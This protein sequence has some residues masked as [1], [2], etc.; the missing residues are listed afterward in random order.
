MKKILFII[1]GLALM[2]IIYMGINVT[3]A[4]GAFINPTPTDNQ[5][6]QAVDV[7]PGTE[8]VTIDQNTGMVFVSAA[9]RRVP[10][11][12]TPD[13]GGIYAFP[14]D[15]PSSVR[16]VSIDG[17]AD[18]QPH[19]I[20]LWR[21]DRGDGTIIT[22]LFVIN[23]ATTGENHIE[24][25]DVAA[26]GSLSYF[27]SIQFQDL[28][29][30]NDILAVGPSSFYATIDRKYKNGLMASLEAYL[31]LPLASTVYFDGF[32]GFTAVEGLKYANGINMSADGN[33]VYIAEVL[34][35]EIGVYARTPAS[36]ALKYIKSIPV[37]TGPDNIEVGGDGSLYVAGHPYVFEFLKHAEDAA[38][39]SP[40]QVLKINP[41]TDQ[42]DTIFMDDQ[43][44][45]NAASV[46]AP[47]GDKLIIGAVFD[48]HVLVCAK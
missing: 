32:E 6:C 1:G 26:D 15:D 24:L 33:I 28:T 29:S 11:G 27:E 45:I 44:L 35:R 18:F 42:V 46:G 7:F 8:D 22:R 4:S 17:P 48:G 39:I 36:G 23:H 20:S 3:R 38:H 31:A 5:L 21:G 2:V 10:N 34:R 41:A 47:Y 25:F 14:I 37:D 9:N 19:G 16:K 40:S 30:P 12:G 13:Q 43:G